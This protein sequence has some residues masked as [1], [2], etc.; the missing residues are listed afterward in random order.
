MAEGLLKAKL[1]TALKEQ[2]VVRSAG[3]LY[4]NG[5]RATPEAIAAVRSYGADIFNHRSQYVSADL[6]FNSDLILVME[7]S[8]RAFLIAEYPEMKESVFLLKEFLRGGDKPDLLNIEDPIGSSH[9]V[10]VATCAEINA[11]IERILP[12]IIQ[13]VGTKRDLVERMDHD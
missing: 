7:E 3:T 11:E 6:V 9:A 4:L 1:S 5:N 13:L 10:Y 2:I 12:G 8:H